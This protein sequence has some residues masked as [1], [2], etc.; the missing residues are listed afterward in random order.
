MRLYKRGGNIPTQVVD[1]HASYNGVQTHENGIFLYQSNQAPHAVSWGRLDW[2]TLLF[3]VLWASGKSHFMIPA[4]V[5]SLYIPR[6]W[7]IQK[8]FTWHAELLPHTEQVVFHKTAMFGQVSKHIVDIK[9]LEKVTADA[10]LN[11][12]MWDGNL[13]DSEFVWQDRQ[14]GEVFVF[15]KLGIWN[16]K[17]LEHPLL[18]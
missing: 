17:A 18:H 8:H 1:N 12:L 2:F 6:R 11:P 9:N 13:F 5:S 15:D 3:Y 4:L 16:K 14:S 10:V 7:S